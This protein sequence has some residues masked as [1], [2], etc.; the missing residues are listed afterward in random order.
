M[1]SCRI[2]PALRIYTKFT[3]DQ[4]HGRWRFKS[5]IILNFNWIMFGK[6]LPI[7]G[8]IIK[9]SRYITGI[10]HAKFMHVRITGIRK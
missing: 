9:I 2:Y 1:A 7:K 8:L 10:Y 5:L 6:L 3:K 4:I